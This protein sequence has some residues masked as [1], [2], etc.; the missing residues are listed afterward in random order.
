MTEEL[1]MIMDCLIHRL[2]QQF[3]LPT[4]IYESL[5]LTMNGLWLHFQTDL[6]ERDVATS[7]TEVEEMVVDTTVVDP[8]A[9]QPDVDY[10]LEQMQGAR[11]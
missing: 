4:T 5:R 6:R 1:K 9:E 2:S 8:P 3:N 11:Q 7:P 10:E